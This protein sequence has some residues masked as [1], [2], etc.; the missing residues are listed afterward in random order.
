MLMT[1]ASKRLA[2][3][4]MQRKDAEGLAGL[5]AWPALFE[6]TGMM[7]ED[8]AYRPRPP[9]PSPDEREEPEEPELALD[10][11]DGAGA[12][13]PEAGAGLEER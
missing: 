6:T 13:P 1:A 12:D 5:Q 4:K 2:P 7:A 8:R 3:E 11:R 10:D 9:L